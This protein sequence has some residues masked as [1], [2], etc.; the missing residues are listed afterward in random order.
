MNLELRDQ[1]E[2]MSGAVVQPMLAMFAMLSMSDH[3]LF[4]AFLLSFV[5]RSYF[6]FLLTPIIV[7]FNEKWFLYCAL[8]FINT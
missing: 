1:L 4:G 3:F 6:A 7:Y 8:N 2:C 5:Q